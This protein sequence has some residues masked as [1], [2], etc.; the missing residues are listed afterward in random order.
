MTDTKKTVT[1]LHGVEGG[2]Q[3]IQTIEKFI[4]RFVTFP[5]D[6][7]SL[8]IA[9]WTMGTF[10]FPAF[11]A[12]PYMV[13][14]AETKRA[15]KTRLAEMIHFVC[16]NPRMMTAVTPSTMFNMIEAERPTI[17]FDEAETM[18]GEAQSA[19]TQILNSGYRKGQT[20][21]RM[22]G[23]TEW[24]EFNVYSPKVFILIGDV[25]DTLRDRAINVKM[26]RM[27]GMVDRFIWEPVKAEGAEIRERA[28]ELINQNLSYISN[29]FLNYKGSDFLEDREE[30]I[31][32]P[33][34]VLCQVF[35]PER[36]EE[37]KRIAVDMS[38]EKT[39]PKQ[40]YKEL[41]E[42][43]DQMEDEK[44]KRQL[45]SD[46]ANVMN[47]KN[48]S[49]Q[50]AVEALKNITTAPWR[51]Y[52]GVGIDMRKL[53]DM[54]QQYGVRPSPVRI[55]TGKHGSNSN[56]FAGYSYKKV[57]EANKRVNG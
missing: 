54:L 27:G 30:E 17:F 41:G 3:I 18:S 11:D 24:K 38:M 35:C 25:R 14:T 37:L 10:C 55:G 15:G 33:L 39:A 48:I 20:I 52:K 13:I 16:S 1:R 51:K 21:P 4:K 26:R 5:D 8:P 36:L 7:M 43:D 42:V 45:L 57:Q 49:S 40:V 23:K 29:A 53:A 12:F 44:Y 56:V 6:T 46:L 47:G 2:C 28:S 32:T 9:L 19:M 22:I 31:W 34:F 50:D